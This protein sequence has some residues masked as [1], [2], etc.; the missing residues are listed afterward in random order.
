MKGSTN[1][2]GFTVPGSNPGPTEEQ[3]KNI[4]FLPNDY[5]AKCPGDIIEDL[6]ELV[7]FFVDEILKIFFQYYLVKNQL[8]ISNNPLSL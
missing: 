4:A 7:M 1:R 2:R 8:L 5:W 6:D 3:T